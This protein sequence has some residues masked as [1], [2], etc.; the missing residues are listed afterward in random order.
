RRLAPSLRSS[1]NGFGSFLSF[2]D[3]SGLIRSVAYLYLLSFIF[4]SMTFC[5]DGGLL[6]H[7][8]GYRRERV[9]GV[10]ADQTDGADHDHQNYGEH[11]GVFRDV[12]PF[13]IAPQEFSQIGHARLLLALR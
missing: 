7:V 3:N 6:L 8:A 13:F 1:T 5:R 10:A 11:H 9:V 4:A 2:R 12:L